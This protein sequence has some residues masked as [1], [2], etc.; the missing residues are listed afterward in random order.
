MGEDMLQSALV[1]AAIGIA[2]VLVMAFIGSRR[3]PNFDAPPRR[4]QTLQSPLSPADALARIKALAGSNKLSLAAEEPAKG[5]VVLADTMSLASFG[6]FYPVFAKAT[7][8]GS[9]LVVGIQPKTPQYGPVVSSKLRKI[10]EAV[11]G[12]VG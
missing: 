12:A 8:G 5:L 10:V 2:V 4:N 11:R 6:N 1:G 7:P 3:K 9:E